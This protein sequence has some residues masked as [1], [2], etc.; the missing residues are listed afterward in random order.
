MRNKVSTC[1][2]LETYCYDNPSR[3]TCVPAALYCWGMY[4]PMQA[5]GRNLYD[6]RKTCNRDENADGP[7]CYKELGWIESW[8]NRPEV[9][10]EL[11]APKELA[12]KSCNMDSTLI[13]PLSSVLGRVQCA[14][15]P[16][17]VAACSQQEFPHGACTEGQC[18]FGQCR[19]LQSV[20]ARC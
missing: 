11:G 15:M 3:F 16:S 6:V 5:T 8:L 9:K 12:F 19:A 20:L 17:S 4:S 7:L 14:D 13:L 2:R 18:L 10:E 1:Q